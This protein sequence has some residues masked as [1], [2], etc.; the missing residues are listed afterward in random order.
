M[1]KTVKHP[2]FAAAAMGCLIGMALTAHSSGAHAGKGG[3]FVGGMIGGHILTRAMDNDARRTRAAEY[4][5]YNSQPRVVYQ[6]APPQASSGGRS[7]EQRLNELDSL[8]AKGYISQ[9]EYQA[10]RQGILDSL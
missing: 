2:R 9:S 7:A 3:A 6:Q 10:R 5:A 8:A 1:D 4:Q